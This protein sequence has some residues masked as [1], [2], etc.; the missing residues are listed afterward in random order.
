MDDL[1]QELI[2]HADGQPASPRLLQALQQSP[3]LRAQLEQARTEV[4]LLKTRLAPL[5]LAPAQSDE[6]VHRIA[7]ELPARLHIIWRLGLGAAAAACLVVA[8]GGYLLLRGDPQTAARPPE[9]GN[10]TA[11]TWRVE[12]FSP[13]GQSGLLQREQSLSSGDKI[14]LG[15]YEYA[16]I[17]DA[18]SETRCLA[19]PGTRLTANGELRLER[20]AIEVHPGVAMVAAGRSYR[21]QATFLISVSGA[22]TQLDVY[23]GSVT[24]DDSGQSRVFDKGRHVLGV[25]REFAGVDA[26]AAYARGFEAWRVNDWGEARAQFE[27]AANSDDIDSQSRN[28]AHFYWFAAAGCAGDKAAAVSIAEGYIKRYPQDA[29]LDYVRYFMGEYLLELNRQQAAREQLELVAQGPAGTLRDLASSRLAELEGRGLTK[30]A[31]L[32]QG[33]LTAWQGRDFSRGEVL[34]RSLIENYPTDASVQSG[35]ASFRL[36]G[37]VGNQGRFEEAITLADELFIKHPAFRA[38]DYV[39]YFK[40]Y[41]LARLKRHAEA[42]AALEQLQSRYPESSMRPYGEDLRKELLK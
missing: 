5:R 12:R 41:Y 9:A 8:L 14:E 38:N 29:N 19:L 27:I 2:E 31:A 13:A 6:I 17:I 11:R 20:G 34:L 10:E 28:F 26:Q 39:L 25:A 15:S 3:E 22:N 23:S 16:T 4:A 21:S 33:F 30:A 1:R 35:D 40:A 32:W 7:H 42:L 18:N 36:F 24:Q 37:C